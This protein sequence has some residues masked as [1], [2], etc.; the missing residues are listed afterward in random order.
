MS[1]ENPEPQNKSKEVSFFETSDPVVENL[2]DKNPEY[3]SILRK[4][5]SEL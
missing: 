5:L 4:N 3:G 2:V 1:F